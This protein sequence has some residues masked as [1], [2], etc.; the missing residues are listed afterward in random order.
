MDFNKI[1]TQLLELVGGKDNVS[2][3][4][5]CMTRLRFVLKDE[6]ICD[7]EQIRKTEGVKGIV[8]SG[9]QVQIIIGK[10]V[11]ELCT[12]VR[13]L[14]GLSGMESS[15]NMNVP[16]M[17]W[18]ERLLDVLSGTMIP[19]IGITIG[20]G[21]VLALMALLSS[22]GV[23]STENG[24][25]QFFYAVGNTSLYFLP[26]FA[27]YTAAQKMNANPFMGMLL[28]ATLLSPDLISLTAAEEG[29]KLFGIT[30]SAFT[31]GNT[32]IPIILAVWFMSYVEKFAKKICPKVISSF[33]VPSIV[34]L[35]TVPLTYLVIGPLG[36]LLTNGISSGVMFLSNHVPF[37]GITVAAALLPI[38]VMSGLHM[39]L[40]PVMITIISSVGY[41]PIIAPAF[42]VYNI[43][44]SGT[45]FAFGLKARGSERKQLGLSCA[46][47]S[48]LGVTEPTLFGIMVTEKKPLITTICACG[49]TGI[50]AGFI[51]Y[52]AYVPM[53]QSLFSIPAAINGG[54]GNVIRCVVLIAVSFAVS[55]AA[56]WLF[57][58]DNSKYNN[59][60]DGGSG[61]GEAKSAGDVDALY[62][63][64][65]GKVI[66][67]EEVK[68]ETFA[69]KT[70]GDGMAIEPESEVLVAPAD[71]EISLVM[72]GS[73][74]ACGLILANGVELLLHIGLD[75]VSMNGD[76]F[77]PYVKAGDKVKKGDK[78]IA[79]DKKKIQKAGCMATVVMVVTEG[80]EDHP[81]RF[82][83][84]ISVQVGDEIAAF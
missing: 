33:G 69:Q 36:A 38:L 19:L 47:S 48:V 16:K 55:F 51:G 84:G 62:A 29:L 83:S 45:A 37:L 42:M 46:V 14:S 63:Y 57:G 5:N 30:L 67:I 2:S 11:E 76:G 32:V 31:Y 34:I 82:R 4:Q 26:V 1:G 56:T 66:P 54:V 3:V 68:D 81:V 77:I 59:R 64:V 53:S 35:I 24:T 18:H 27:G 15:E 58:V 65:S 28:G 75:T 7:D 21:M 8:H 20:G 44:A 6:S 40:I 79:F 72:E 17:K 60:S 74:H 73:N 49:I 43:A 12:Q 41:D 22:I 9:G 61:E 39:S 80:G 23:L 25:Y 70:L 10:G 13:K 71:G 52:A 50:L 78:L